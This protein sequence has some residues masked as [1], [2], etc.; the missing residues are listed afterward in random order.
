MGPSER[1]RLLYKLA[2]LIEKNIDK[3]NESNWFFLSENPK[4]IHLIE[5]NLDK[6]DDGCWSFLSKNPNIFEIEHEYHY[7]EIRKRCLI[8]KEELIQK[9]MHPSRIQKLLDSGIS[10]DE[11]DNCM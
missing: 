6:L 2:D 11:L 1:G 4:A 8:Y 9:T 10:I 3:L 7:E 5:K